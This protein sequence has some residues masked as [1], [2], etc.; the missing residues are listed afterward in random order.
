MI[1]EFC[2]LLPLGLKHINFLVFHFS[3]FLE[4]NQ[5]SSADPALLAV[6]ANNI[7]CINK[8]QNIFDSR[9]RIKAASVDG[10]KHKLFAK[11]RELILINQ[12]LFYW[13][14]NQV[15]FLMRM[16]VMYF[17]YSNSLLFRTK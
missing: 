5:K 2:L 11:Q 4:I 1:S 8:E 16:F 13:H 9:K 17:L 15:S 6:A 3:C 14:T 7:V 12:A 10:L